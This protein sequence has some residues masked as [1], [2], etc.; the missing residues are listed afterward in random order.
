MTT[1]LGNTH[2]SQ[3]RDNRF[4]KLTLEHKILDKPYTRNHEDQAYIM[5]VDIHKMTEWRL[6]DCPLCVIED[7]CV[8]MQVW[9]EFSFWIIFHGFLNN[10]FQ[11]AS[12][13]TRSG[14]GPVLLLQEFNSVNECFIPNLLSWLLSIIRRCIGPMQRD[15]ST[16]F[17]VLFSL[18]QSQKFE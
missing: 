11:D 14:H 9:K 3:R 1:L 16:L 17:F 4:T 10:A 15:T 18:V 8:M 7:L 13:G 6:F 5:T 2:S 12:F